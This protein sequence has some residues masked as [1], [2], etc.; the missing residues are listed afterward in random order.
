MIRNTDWQNTVRLKSSRSHPFNTGPPMHQQTDLLLKAQCSCLSKSLPLGH[1]T[2]FMAPLVSLKHLS[3]KIKIPF[4]WLRLAPLPLHVWREAVFVHPNCLENRHSTLSLKKAC[5]PI[6][7]KTKA[8]QCPCA[9]I[10]IP[11]PGKRD[12]KVQ[13]WASYWNLIAE[14]AVRFMEL[15]WNQ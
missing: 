6:V 7:P 10:A 13:Q 3:T 4:I 5:W 15:L 14:M 12:L 1:L 9:N 2:K 11:A 8:H